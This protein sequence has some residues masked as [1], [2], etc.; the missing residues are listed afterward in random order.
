M[1]TLE[2][3]RDQNFI[4]LRVQR[5]RLHSLDAFP[6][7]MHSWSVLW[8]HLLSQAHTT[9]LEV[10]AL[11]E[12][13]RIQNRIPPSS[14][15]SSPQDTQQSLRSSL[16]ILWKRQESVLCT[17]W[18]VRPVGTWRIGMG[19]GLEGAG[20]VKMEPNTVRWRPH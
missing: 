10:F 6:S 20:S 14:C 11:S 19:V 15:K 3:A 9:L 18:S 7:R 4:H 17:F 2:H 12:G 8:S 1:S 16:H 5:H 13:S